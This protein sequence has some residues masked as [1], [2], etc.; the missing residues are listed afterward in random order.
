M[1]M[2]RIAGT[3]L[4]LALTSTAP[5]VLAGEGAHTEIVIGASLPLSGGE[6][7]AGARVRDGYDLAF[8]EAMKKGGLLVGGRRIPVR[9]KVVDD[10]TN[11]QRA[12]ELAVD[13]VEKQGAD[14]LLG[15]FS[16]PVVEA[17][18]AA[19]EKLKVPY[20]TSSGSASSLYQRGFRYLFSVSAPIEQLATAIMRW[21]DDAQRAGKLPKPLRIAVAWEKTSHGKDMRAGVVSYVNA[22]P[23]RS[24]AFKVVEDQS[25]ELNTKQFKP[26]LSRIQAANADVL[27]VD[28]HLQEYIAMQR[29]YL[30]MGMC[31][32]VISYGARGSEKEARDALPRGGTD[33][34][35]SAV[36]WE[37]GMGFNPVSRAFAEAFNAKFKRV[38]E[39]YEALAYEAARALFAAIEKAGSLDRER[40]RES[41]TTLKMDSILPGEYLA[42]PEQ[43]GYQA[44]YLFVVQQNMPNGSSPIIYP[45]IAQVQEGVVPN[46]RCT[47]TAVHL[48]E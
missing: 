43:Y 35:I 3:A 21:L 9:L 31:H 2:S 33:Y 19:A 48:R 37:A 38:P 42:F 16:T 23:L 7:K 11:P 12:A 39:W 44:H 41:L 1:R 8:A 36:W 27:L 32:K 34:V 15:S 24:A 47:T 29:E 5:A 14:F 20:V 4:L 30:A 25:F 46:P 18:S 22:T 17:Q 40:V 45:E 6:A 28:A 26:L 10:G 13:L